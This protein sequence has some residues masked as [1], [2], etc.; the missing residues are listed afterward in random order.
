VIALLDN[1][2]LSNFSVVERADL[3]RRAL[4]EDAAT[5]QAVWDELQAGV[6]MSR[7]PA[8]DWSWLQILSLTEDEREVYDLL[9]RR[10]NAGEASCLA[11]V[12][13]EATGSLLTTGVLEN[14]LPSGGFLF[15]VPWVCCCDWST[16][17][18]CRWL[19]GMICWQE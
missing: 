11:I 8:Q 5:T 1:T 6:R 12:P 17:G 14:W 4:G 18:R 10:L 2:V 9:T 3:V 7:L 15:P 16:S 13:D 19:K